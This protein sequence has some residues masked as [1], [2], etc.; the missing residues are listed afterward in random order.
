M[1]PSLTGKDLV[2]RL[3]VLISCEGHEQLLGVSQL[4]AGTEEEQ[5]VNIFHLLIDWEITVSIVAI[6]FDITA[7][8]TENVKGTCFY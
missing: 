5:A 8:N 7:L 4:S 1:L 6:C 2:E 3:P